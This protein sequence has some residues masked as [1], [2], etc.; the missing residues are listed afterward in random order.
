MAG[1]NRMRQQDR[2]SRKKSNDKHFENRVEEQSN[3]PIV[4]K[5][6]NQKELL[7]SFEQNIISL[8]TGDAGLEKATCQHVGQHNRYAWVNIRR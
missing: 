2:K 5:T 4:A 7:K 1:Q 3:K 8:A 6:P